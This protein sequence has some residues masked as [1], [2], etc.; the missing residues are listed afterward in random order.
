[1]PV[2][3][4][5][6]KHKENRITPE[7]IEAFRAGDRLE[8]RRALGLAPWEESPLDVDADTPCAYSAMTGAALSHA[9]ILDLRAELLKATKG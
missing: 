6:S 4:R 2:K 5:V 8:L 1:M 7:A 3:R 9:K